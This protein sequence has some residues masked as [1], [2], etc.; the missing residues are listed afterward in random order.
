MDLNNYRKQIDE[1]DDQLVKLLSERF[2]VTRKVGEYKK[3]NKL[4]AIDPDREKKQF[5]R[6]KILAKSYGVKPEL[7]SDIFRLV[8]NEVVQN[9]KRTG[10]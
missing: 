7:V 9:H 10:S 6:L 1:I 3:L 5:D 4:E 8:I 2:R